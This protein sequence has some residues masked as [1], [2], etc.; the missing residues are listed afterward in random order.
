MITYEPKTDRG[1]RTTGHILG[2]SGRVYH[3]RVRWV[4]LALESL[5]AA[6]LLACGAGDAAD[7]GFQSLGSGGAPTTTSSTTTSSSNSTTSWS[8]TGGGEPQPKGPPYPIVLAHGFFGFDDF[9]GLGFVDYFYGVKQDLADQGEFLVFTP[10]VDPFNDSVVRG[11]QLAAAIHTILEASGHAKVNIV[12]HSQGGLDA[13]HVAH[14]HPEWVAS[15]ITLQ[16]PH[17]GTPIADIAIKVLADPN[18]QAVL[19]ML[20]QAAGKPVWDAIGDSTS[21]YAS[22]YSFSQQGIADF[23][24]T[25]TDQPGIWYASVAGRSDRHAGGPDCAVATPNF[26]TAANGELDPIDPLFLVSEAILD[27]TIGESFPNDGLV[28]ARDAKWG[29]FLGCVPADHFD[30]IG[31]LLGDSPGAFNDWSYLAFYRDLVHLVRQ[32]GF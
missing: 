10:E 30:M 8:G 28:R 26:I 1:W 29:E 7:P 19:D 31:Q 9:A 3:G 23:N 13:R 32:R 5:G 21:L 18:L 20:L 2:S 27:G 12:G 11:E 15:V 22:L 25:Y 17:G 16:T 4:V 6:T 14:E 24:A